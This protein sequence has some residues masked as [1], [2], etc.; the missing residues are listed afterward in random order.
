MCSVLFLTSLGCDC[1]CSTGARFLERLGSKGG[2]APFCGGTQSPTALAAV[3]LFTACGTLLEV[4][5]RQ[6]KP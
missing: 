4:Q 3:R 5:D 2:R 6:Q 1:R